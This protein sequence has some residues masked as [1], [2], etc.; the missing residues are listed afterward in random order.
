[1]KTNRIGGQ[2]MMLLGDKTNLRAWSVVAAVLAGALTLA[3]CPTRERADE[4]D[5]SDSHPP[6]AS[7]V[8]GHQGIGGTGGTM[9]PP[10]IGGSWAQGGSSGGGGGSRMPDGG[11][12]AGSGGSTMLPPPNQNCTVAAQCASGFCVDGVCCDTACDGACQSCSLTGKV[13]T[14]T[15]VKNGADDAC[16]GGSICDATGA[17][18]KDLGRTCST[19]AECASGSCVDGACCATSGCGTCQACAVPGFEGK[20]AP[21]GRFVDH[22]ECSDKNTCNG[23]GECH[24]KYGSTCSKATDC[25]SLNCVDGVC[26]NTACDGACFSCNQAQS[27]GTCSPVNGAVDDAAATPC[28]GVNICGVAAGGQ[29]HCGLKSG[30]S[31][32]TNAQCASA[33]C[34]TVVVPPDPN[35]P[36]DNGYSY[37]RCD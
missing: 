15:P 34:G 24:G 11:A 25:V 16:N 29:P 33:T 6:D 35:D 28:N 30:Q 37:N 18:R 17:C 21:V 4:V 8:G 36:Y 22:A 1:M 27:P 13:G 31:C 12:T 20:C 10:S 26:C 7:G 14:C 23:Q 3:G 32:A 2:N 19:N 9:P 5:A